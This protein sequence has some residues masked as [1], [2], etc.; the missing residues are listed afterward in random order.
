VAR[1]MAEAQLIVVQVP[2]MV[3]EGLAWELQSINA[4]GL[5][6][7]TL[8]VLPPVPAVPL[9]E[10]WQYL[11]ELLKKIGVSKSALPI[12]PAEMLAVAWSQESEWLVFVADAR[13]EWT[14]AA[15]LTEAAMQLS[16]SPP[17]DERRHQR[18]VVG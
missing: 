7:K 15:T 18:S 13:N 4:Q 8:L 9:R 2:S 17:P 5:W 12:D 6:P 3:T 11:A 10:Q 16:G 14:Y 1:W